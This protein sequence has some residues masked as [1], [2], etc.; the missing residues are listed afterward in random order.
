MKSKEKKFLLILIIV[1]ILIIIMEQLFLNIVNASYYEQQTEEN[2]KIIGLSDVSGEGVIIYINDGSD[3]IHQEDVIILLDEL[4]NAGAEAI[5]VN[6]QRVTINTYIYCDGGVILID[7]QKIGNPFT[8]KAIGDSKTIYGS[9]MRNKGY[10]STLKND[11]IKID[12]D[13]SSNITILKTNKKISKKLEK[14]NNSAK[15]YK[16]TSQIVGKEKI[17]GKGIEIYIDTS[18]EKDI[19]ALTLIQLVNDLNSAGVEAIS[20]NGNRI[21]TMTDMM[22]ISGKYILIDS[23]PVK[24]PYLIKV[25]GNVKKICEVLDYEN[26]TINKL[27]ESGKEVSAYSKFFISVDQYMETRGKNKLNISYIK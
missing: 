2:K 9:I 7:G 4:K 8:I 23:V 11:G 3:L 18:N 13:I 14:I 15:D 6:D 16:I 10:I 17:T 19:T 22:D 27:I 25:V 12:V 26:S 1:S 21:T 24:S 5:S 20:I